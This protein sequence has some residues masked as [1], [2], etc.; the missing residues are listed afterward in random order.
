[1]RVFV[2]GDAEEEDGGDLAVDDLVDDFGQAVQRE[3]VL[4][5]HRGDLAFEVLA[6]VDEEGV[7][8]VVDGELVFPD[9]VAQA[10]V[11]PQAAEPSGGETGWLLGVPS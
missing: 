2:F 4:A 6:V 11:L 1:M 5:G 7:D 3:L 8:E 10:G 9:E